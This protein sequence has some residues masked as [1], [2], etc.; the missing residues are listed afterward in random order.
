MSFLHRRR[1]LGLKPLSQLHHEFLSRPNAKEML[2]EAE[3]YLA[4]RDDEHAARTQR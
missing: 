2:V 3:E 1:E 4:A